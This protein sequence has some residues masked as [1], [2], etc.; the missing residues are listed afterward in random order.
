MNIYAFGRLFYPKQLAFNSF[1]QFMLSLGILTL[2]ATCS[3]F[4]LQDRTQY[5][6]TN[7][8]KYKKRTFIE[9]M[10][11]HCVSNNSG[12]IWKL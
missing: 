1:D 2:L 4:E 8:T 10:R 3:M 7:K 12:N 6:L 9:V 5:G 11:A